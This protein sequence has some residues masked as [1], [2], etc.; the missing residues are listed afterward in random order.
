MTR[1]DIL[2][3]YAAT[4]IWFWP[5]LW[6]NLWRLDAYMAA[7]MAAGESVL[8]E[9]FTNGR[10]ALRVRWIAEA[11]A[12]TFWRHDGP[13]V[14]ELVDLDA[15]ARGFAAA[16]CGWIPRAGLFGPTCDAPLYPPFAHLEP[17]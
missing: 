7:R 13:G 4:P 11:A 12:P 9:I 5:V 16:A 2:R 3:L 15:Y 10:G 6:W 1:D 14:L 8:A 17:G